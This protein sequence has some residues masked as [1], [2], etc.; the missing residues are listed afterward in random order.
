MTRWPKIV[1]SAFLWLV[2]LGM[3]F[4]LFYM[5]AVSFSTSDSGSV[6]TIFRQGLSWGNY[7]GVFSR[8]GLSRFIFNSVLV[9]AIVTA[10][11]LAFCLMVGY[12]LARRRF[13]G[14]NLLFM[15]AAAVLMIPAH[16]VIIPVF[17]LISKLGL[18]NTYWA[19]ILPFLVS[20][21]GV[22]LMAQYIK[23]L[24][25][26]CEQAARIDGANEFVILIKIVAP[27]CK[28][29]LAVLAVQSFLTNWN[30]FV[31]PFI[32]TSSSDL[33]TLP[34]GLAM[35]QGLQGISIPQ[36]MSGSTIATLPVVIVFLFFQRQIVEGI[37]AG[38][39]KG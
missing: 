36:V 28:P 20:P 22:F 13:I 25:D 29:A 3:L 14:N 11:N 4:P 32:L 9:A 6:G 39:V 34:V 7:L 37:T 10:G 35:M 30:S 31:Y 18:Y 16:V 8:G 33:Y 17:I 19:L 12:A 5:V 15:S 21:L 27:L 1:L 23:S 38:A 24:P 26:E 2:L